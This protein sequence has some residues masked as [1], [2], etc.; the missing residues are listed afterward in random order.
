MKDPIN[1]FIFTHI[2][3]EFNKDMIETQKN[4]K[5]NNEIIVK[6]KDNNIIEYEK[7]GK[8]L[9][10]SLYKD[11]NSLYFST[12]KYTGDFYSDE[13]IGFKF[14]YENKNLMLIKYPFNYY[15]DFTFYDSKNEGVLEI[16][17]KHLFEKIDYSKNKISGY[18]VYMY[19][20]LYSLLNAKKAEIEKNKIVI[21]II[22]EDVDSFIPNYINEISVENKNDYF[23][24]Y[25]L[26]LQNHTGT[27]FYI[28]GKF[29]LYDSSHSFVLKLEKIFKTIAKQIEILNTFIIQN[30]GTCLFHNIIFLETILPYITEN[31]KDIFKSKINLIFK[32]KEFL[33]NYINRLNDLCG[34]EKAKIIKNSTKEE[35]EDYFLLN[36]DIYLSKKSFKF[37]LIDYNNLFTFL[38]IKSNKF[39]DLIL[40]ENYVYL[41]CYK[42]NFLYNELE[43]LLSNKINDI[44]Y[45][46][47]KVCNEKFYRLKYNDSFLSETILN[48]YI[49]YIENKLNIEESFKLELKNQLKEEI[50]QELDLSEIEFPEKCTIKDKNDIDIIIKLMK[51]NLKYE[52]YV[53]NYYD[54]YD[55]YNKLY[56]LIL[57]EKENFIKEQ[58]EL[59]TKFENFNYKQEK[60]LNSFFE[61][62]NKNI[63]ALEKTLKE[64]EDLIEVLN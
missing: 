55:Y 64:L 52:I 38:G 35:S 25:V 48:N 14:F 40:K 45:K 49:N 9:K 29:Y 50:R 17:K 62:I 4:E 10:E 21:K 57:S 42:I 39:A 13:I 58:K 47:D 59:I 26:L 23:F 24:I 33:F 20:Y 2:I 61:D 46:V 11:G 7:N 37:R 36:K 32:S 19:F 34:S 27:L 43:T 8:I 56:K 5:I 51:E 3:K 54:E 22:D 41:N 60:N 6:M 53:N 44:D 12:I 28:N 31:N 30:L 18:K 16:I 15:A 1:Y 63:K